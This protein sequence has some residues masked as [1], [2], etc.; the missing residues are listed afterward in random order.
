MGA[1][2]QYYSFPK[3]RW[4]ALFDGT[5]PGAA[6]ELV[7]SAY[8]E[9]AEGDLP[10]PDEDRA[11]YLAAVGAQAPAE[12]RDLAGRLARAGFDYAAASPAEARRL[13]QLVCGFFCPEGLE[14]VLGYRIEGGDGLA[15]AALDELLG[16]AS[17]W[18]GGGFLGFGARRIPATAVTLAPFLKTGRRIGTAAAPHVEHRY[19]LFDP[20]E[21]TV[22]LREVDALLAVDRPWVIDEFRQA[23]IDEV[24]AAL[25]A[26]AGRGDCLAARYS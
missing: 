8:W 4:D 15:Q 11:G 12:L 9:K 26:A 16:R 7:A 1:F 24:R 17:A 13:D 10:D 14:P 19:F 22:A 25:A 18:S 3:P 20:G 21:V 6:A 23:V 2:W 5:M